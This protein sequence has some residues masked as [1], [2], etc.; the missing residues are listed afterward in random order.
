[1]EANWQGTIDDIDPEFLHEFRVAVRRTRSGAPSRQAGAGPT[2]DLGRRTGSGRWASSPS[3]PRD[4]DVYVLEWDD[5]VGD[6]AAPR[7]SRRSSRC[8]PSCD[9]D[10]AAAHDE[11]AVESAL[12]AVVDLLLERWSAWLAEIARP[13]GRRPARRASDRS[14]S[15]GERIREGPATAS[16]STAGRSRRRPR[17]RTSTSCART[18]RSCATCSSASVV[19]SRRRSAQGLRQAAQ[20]VAGQP[21]RAPGRRGARRPA[22]PDRRPSCRRRPPAETFVAIGQLIEQLEQ[23]RQDARDEFAERFAAYDAKATRRGSARR[24]STAPADEGARHLQHQG[25]RREDHRRG[26]PRPFEAARTRRTRAAVGPRPAGRGDL[27]L[28]CQAVAQG[29][30]R[31]A[32]VR[33]GELGDHVRAS[34]VPG[35]ARAAGRLLAAPPR[36]APRRRH[37]RSP[38][39]PAGAARRRTTTWPCSTARRAS[40]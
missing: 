26:E 6:L 25:R 34:D 18:P 31:T 20:G 17:R 9:A 11:L 8:A 2:S 5:Y 4:L 13:G 1:M 33:R 32:G 14:T 39:R 30:C 22:A 27:L 37:D 35:A 3:P 36:L 29:R 24:C 38:R 12:G 16:S 21:R 28:A 15:S 10:R 7:R 40:R 23:I 19:C